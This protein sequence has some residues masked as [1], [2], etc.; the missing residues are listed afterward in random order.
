MCGHLARMGEIRDVYMVLVEEP[1]GK[2]PLIR[3]TRR[4]EDNIKMGIHEVECG[5]MDWMELAQDRYRWR[6]LVKAVMNL[7]FS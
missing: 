7:R 4:W 5:V 3:P 2:I 6:A 1:E